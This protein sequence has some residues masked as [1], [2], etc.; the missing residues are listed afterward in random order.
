MDYDE[1]DTVCANYSVETET[2]EYRSIMIMIKMIM[3]LMV[4]Y[5]DQ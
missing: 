2:L 3:L 1:M 5:D 4:T